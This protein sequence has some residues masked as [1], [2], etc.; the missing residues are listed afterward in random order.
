M[1][2]LPGRDLW[3]ASFICILCFKFYIKFSKGVKTDFALLRELIK[4]IGKRFSLS[5]SFLNLHAKCD[6]AFMKP[7]LPPT[8]A[9]L[10]WDCLEK[11]ESINLSTFSTLFLSSTFAKKF[12]LFKEWIT[13][14]YLLI[15]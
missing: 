9:I 14:L 10:S 7:F 4:R 3:F 12:A 13:P 11:I 6:I 5:K 15:L 2:T 1:V 8:N